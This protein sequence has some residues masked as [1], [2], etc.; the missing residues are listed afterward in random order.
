VAGANTLQA[1]WAPGMTGDKILDALRG[2]IKFSHRGD[3]QAALGS[4]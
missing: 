2:S 1:S 4:A 3:V